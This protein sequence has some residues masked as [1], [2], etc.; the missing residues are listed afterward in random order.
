MSRN[1]SLKVPPD[2]IVEDREEREEAAKPRQTFKSLGLFSFLRHGKTGVKA[3]VVQ[4]G[5]AVPI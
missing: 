4:Y 5:T 2:E 1:I 3:S